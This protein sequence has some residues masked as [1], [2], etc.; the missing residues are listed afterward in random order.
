MT[1]DFKSNEQ[2]NQ[3]GFEALFEP[4]SLTESEVLWIRITDGLK[5]LKVKN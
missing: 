4:L 1:V 3:Q 5:L 2:I